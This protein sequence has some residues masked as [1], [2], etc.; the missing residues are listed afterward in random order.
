MYPRVVLLLGIVLVAAHP[1]EGAEELAPPAASC[2]SSLDQDY[3]NQL[4]SRVGGLERALE[5]EQRARVAERVEAASAR[6]RSQRE[7]AARLATLAGEL[8]AR[9]ASLD[10]ASKK[11]RDLEALFSKLSPLLG[12]KDAEIA[13]LRSTVDDRDRSLGV[14]TAELAR[15]GKELG[16]ARAARDSKATAD[17]KELAVVRE[18]NAELAAT[19][20]K[21]RS[22]IEERNR[23]LDAKGA[24]LA[25]LEKELGEARAVQ[26]SNDAAERE[27]LAGVRG[28]LE[29][30]KAALGRLNH[31]NLEQQ[32][33]IDH[34]QLER[35]KP[36]TN[37]RPGRTLTAMPISTA[38]AEADRVLVLPVAGRGNDP[39]ATDLA[40]ALARRDEIERTIEKLKGSPGD[41]SAP[42]KM[43]KLQSELEGIKREILRFTV[44]MSG[45][46]SSS[47]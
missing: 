10:A 6:E 30:A 4:L 44:L 8:R 41:R 22:A 32:A 47:P 12:V 19:A 45:V 9:G 37:E 20:D 11:T 24:E 40:A 29:Q 35:R 27:E 31:E 7:E 23:S 38:S 42:A 46:V 25:R 36:S 18:K 13:K 43:A 3:L 5:T 1:A 14:K 21:L 39:L 34:L 33:T 28:Q 2:G 26:P 17:G 15:L 16:E